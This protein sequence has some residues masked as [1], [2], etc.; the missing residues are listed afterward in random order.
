MPMNAVM[1][2]GTATSRVFASRVRRLTT[3]PAVAVHMLETK[4]PGPKMLS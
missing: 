4:Q 1:V 2:P 3:R